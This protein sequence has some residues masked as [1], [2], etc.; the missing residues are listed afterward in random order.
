MF[1]FRLDEKII[2]F[3][4][5]TSVIISLLKIFSFLEGN[6]V[7]VLSVVG[8]L[9]SILMLT[10]YLSDNFKKF[11][12]FFLIT[13]IIIYLIPNKFI[14]DKIASLRFVSKC[15]KDAISY[16][17]LFWS[18]LI[19]G[20][21]LTLIF[22]FF[23][24][25][26]SK[27]KKY[28]K[29]TIFLLREIWIYPFFVVSAVIGIKIVILFRPYVMDGAMEKIST[30]LFGGWNVDTWVK[31]IQNTFCYNWFLFFYDA[32]TFYP[33]LLST[34]SFVKKDYE[35][36]RKITLSFVIAGITGWI[37]YFIFPVVGPLY[38]NSGKG[39]LANSFIP[40]NCFPSLHT[41]WG[42]L[43]LIYA[44][45]YGKKIFYPFLFA[46]SMVILATI[47]LRLHYIIDLLASI[48]HTLLVV[49]LTEKLWNKYYKNRSFEGIFRWER[50]KNEKTY[51]LVSLLFIFSGISALILE[52][53]FLQKL[54]L[55]FGSTSVAVTLILSIY[56]LGMAIGN[57]LGGKLADRVEIPVKFYALFEMIIGI[58]SF[59]SIY[60]FK[61]IQLFYVH[62]VKM[63][64][65][66]SLTVG[67]IR[68]ILIVVVVIIPT[69]AMGATFPLLVKQL[70]NDKEKLPR[71][72]STLY[73]A[74][75]FGAALGVLSATYILFPE[76]GLKTTVFIA[77][78]INFIVAYVG[79]RLSKSQSEI[80]KFHKSLKKD[81]LSTPTKDLSL[82]TSIAILVV[83][84]SLGLVSFSL[85][86]LWTHILAMVVGNSSYAF[87][88]M[89]FAVLVGLGIG[90]YMA[91]A[92][93]FERDRKIK[94]IWHL[95]LF[96]SLTI[97]FQIYIWDKLPLIFEFLPMANTFPKREFVRFS[98]SFSVLI[99]PTTLIGTIFPLLVSVFSENIK[100]LGKKVGTISFFNTLGDIIGSIIGGFVLIPYL[101]SY[102]SLTLISVFSGFL[103]IL[104]LVLI[105]KEGKKIIKG[106][107]ISFILLFLILILPPWDMTKLSLGTNVYFSRQGIG[108]VIDY[109]E[110][111]DGGF[112]TVTIRKVGKYK[113]LTLWTNGKFQGD[114]GYE[115]EAQRGFA[116]YPILFAR[117]RDRALVVGLG[118]GVTASVVYEAKFKY[119][120]ISEISPGI[121]EAAKKY[122]SGIND[123]ILEKKNVH[124]HISDGRNFLLLNKTPYDLITMEISSIWF[125]GAAS[126]YSKEFYEI[127]M[128]NL[129]KDGIFQQWIQLHHISR[130]DVLS[131]VATIKSVFPHVRLFVA[132][133]QG[134]L[135]ASKSPLKI[136][137]KDLEDRIIKYSVLKRFSPYHSVY[138]LMGNELLG[139]K[140]IKKF[141]TYYSHF[142]NVDLNN[143]ISTDDNKYLEY[144]T[145][146][147]N[148]RPYFSSL[149][150]NLRMLYP[151]RN[152]INTI[153]TDL[154]G[155][156][157][158]IFAYLCCNIVRN[159]DLVK[160][161]IKLES[162]G[163]KTKDKFLKKKIKNLIQELRKDKV[164]RYVNEGK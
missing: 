145:P 14:L 73:S 77:I 96:L 46:V 144:S 39:N 57:Y 49:Y 43:V 102:K 1:K 52:T 148:V 32:L 88:I 120:D 44:K 91:R 127:A 41:T 149:L 67:A 55:I 93:D 72:V 70:G 19:I 112:T 106:V 5:L 98:V 35:T 104:L 26:S 22:V 76:F 157:W 109:W 90:G 75:I 111:K 31:S 151:F 119:I 95:L 51:Y 115:M 68:V 81:F 130:M 163:R 150:D 27:R 36:L 21:I 141:L 3:M 103:A 15:N 140:G 48:P 30:L 47:Y 113:S 84:F 161:V 137:W 152:D 56:M 66:S 83:A 58:F 12:T 71:V 164:I 23:F 40:R 85:E 37:L 114:D 118:T 129:K 28:L 156:Q 80:K 121:V 54:T 69:I 133:N 20:A 107:G 33:I 128:N 16:I 122:F 61:Y 53:F 110:E 45:K 138:C 154:P 87:G 63:T 108:K 143:I 86:V 82:K 79:W 147:G 25:S 158:E 125:A 89:L 11:L 153:L 74:N 60:S 124:L 131:I 99:L 132:K 6:Y 136:R 116:L 123:N 62:L 117:R 24:S 59:I 34:Y 64:T 142:Y 18:G 159:K 162:L 126:L 92:F 2:I 29:E 105:S 50:I 155:P 160:T 78:F 65:L 42:L 13:S 17:L 139:E 97:F 94:I 100:F 10:I 8:I 135:V 134:I 101:G 7:L 38:Y 146:R 9:F 4:F